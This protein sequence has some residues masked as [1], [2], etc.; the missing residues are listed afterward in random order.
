MSEWGSEGRNEGGSEWGRE[1]II[2]HKK[3]KFYISL[4]IPEHTTSMYSLHTGRLYAPVVRPL[5][6]LSSVIEC[7][8]CRNTSMRGQSVRDSLS[9]PWRWRSSKKQWSKCRWPNFGEGWREGEMEG[10]SNSQ[11][12]FFAPKLG[13]ICQLSV[14]RKII[15]QSRKYCACSMIQCFC[16]F[17]KWRSLPRGGVVGVKVVNSLGL[18]PPTFYLFLKVILSNSN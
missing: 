15:N 17:H 4:D 16:I 18:S 6:M 5:L 10:V 8:L 12:F 7:N 13:R 3:Q 2:I 14:D 1:C 9:P 11:T